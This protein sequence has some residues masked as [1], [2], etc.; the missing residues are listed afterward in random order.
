MDYSGGF[1]MSVD[2]VVELEKCPIQNML[3]VRR[4]RDHGVLNYSRTSLG[5]AVR[6]DVRVR[7]EIRDNLRVSDDVALIVWRRAASRK[8]G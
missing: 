1:G 3:G 4:V 2:H 8:S 7:D 6:E 5:G